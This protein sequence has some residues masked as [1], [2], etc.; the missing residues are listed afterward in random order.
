MLIKLSFLGSW[1]TWLQ[2]LSFNA[3]VTFI[4][5]NDVNVFRGKDYVLLI[6][7]LQ[8]KHGERVHD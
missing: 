1:L 3:M 7:F 5:K 8:M 2:V 4:D 6:Y